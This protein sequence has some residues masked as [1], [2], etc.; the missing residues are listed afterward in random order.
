MIG[1]KDCARKY[2]ENSI[3]TAGPGTLVLMLFDGAIRAMGV[4]HAAFER[5]KT[6]FHRIEIINRELLKAQAI[7]TELRGTLNHEIGGDY[8][9][10]MDPLYLY[11]KRRLIEANMTKQLEPLAEVE[12]LFGTLREAWADMLRNHDASESPRQMLSA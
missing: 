7:F 11:F 5:S 4:A 1:A 3:L 2:R 9:K 12:Q 6:D 10:T 8:A